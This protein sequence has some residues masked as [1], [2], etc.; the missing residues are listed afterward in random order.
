MSQNRTAI[1]VYASAGVV[2]LIAAIT[3]DVMI[4]S[5]SA[6]SPE[7]RRPQPLRF[8]PDQWIVNRMPG[9]VPAPRGSLPRE[10]FI[11]RGK[12]LEIARFDMRWVRASCRIKRQTV[13]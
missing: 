5:A 3:A 7:L 8:C 2:T 11:H 10:Y 4:S 6:R 13:W 9:V 1:F 12:R